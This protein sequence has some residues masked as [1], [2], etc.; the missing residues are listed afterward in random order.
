LNVPVNDFFPI[1]KYRYQQYVKKIGKQVN[2]G[3]REVRCRP[4]KQ[5][6][7]ES[8]PHQRLVPHNWWMIVSIS[9]SFE[10]L[11]AA[12]KSRTERASGK[13]DCRTK[14]PGK[15][16]EYLYSS[17]YPSSFISF[18]GAVRKASGTARFPDRRPS[19]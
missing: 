8:S 13:K 6:I 16:C 19:S 12:K 4:D 1:G 15:S 5:V 3:E 14:L 17:P 7:C 11:P 18:V 9:F 10:L 2:N